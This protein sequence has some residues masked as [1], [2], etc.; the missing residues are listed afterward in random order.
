M[1]PNGKLTNG[2]IVSLNPGDWKVG[3]LPIGPRGNSTNG[4]FEG[5]CPMGIKDRFLEMLCSIHSERREDLSSDVL[6]WASSPEPAKPG[7]FKPG[8]SPALTKA[9]SGLG[10]GFKSQK[11]EP[12][13]QA[14]A[15]AYIRLVHRSATKKV[16]LILLSLR[17]TRIIQIYQNPHL[18]VAVG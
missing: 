10:P 2:L 13:A 11:P 3:K 5:T 16:D 1:A 6:G 14:R 7:P 4:R 8:R 15:L 12:W 18:Y 17:Q 9:W